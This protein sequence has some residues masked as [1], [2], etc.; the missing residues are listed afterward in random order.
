MTSM[1][2]YIHY[3]RKRE[4]K[5]YYTQNGERE[6]KNEEKTEHRENMT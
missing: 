4:K 2:L 6:K 1:I 3:V 5:K